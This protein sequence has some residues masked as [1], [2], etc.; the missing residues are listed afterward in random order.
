MW[1]ARLA[2][3]TVIFVF[4]DFSL[5]LQRRTKIKA[6]DFA[7]NRRMIL[8]LPG[9][10]GRGEGERKSFSDSYAFLGFTAL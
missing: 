6:R 5:S 10:E 4:A 8:P 7:K 2:N 9:G 1:V 3:S